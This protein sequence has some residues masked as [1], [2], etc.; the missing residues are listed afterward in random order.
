MPDY[1]HPSGYVPGGK[2][3]TLGGPPRL[4]QRVPQTQSVPGRGPGASELRPASKRRGAL[5][6][7]QALENVPHLVWVGGGG[8]WIVTRGTYCDGTSPDHALVVYDDAGRLLRD[9]RLDELVTSD[10]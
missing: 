6:W 4:L 8:R 3:G 10:K 2:I 7:T 9:W 1:G 5:V